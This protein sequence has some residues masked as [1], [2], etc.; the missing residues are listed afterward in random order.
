ME[1]WKEYRLSELCDILSGGTPKTTEPKYWGGGIPW[2]SVKDFGNVDKY[3][4]TTEK[5]ITN[6][7]FEH[8]P[9]KMLQ[10]DDIIISARGTVGAIAMISSSMS[11]N[12]SCFGLRG[13][14]LVDK[15]F[16]YYLMHTKVRELRSNSHGSVF[17][18]ITRNTFDNIICNIP[19]KVI[20]HKIATI[21]SFLDDKIELNRKINSNLEEQAKALF[22]SWFIDF[23]PFKDGKFVDSELGKIPEGWKVGRYDDIVSATVVGDWGKDKPIGNYVHEVTCIRGCD[24]QDIKNGLTGN[25]PSRF[26]LE[27]NFKNKCFANNDILVEISGGTQTV[28]TGR[29]CPISQELISRYN[30]NVVCTNFCRVLRPIE[31]YSAFI[32]YSWLYK[33]NHKVMFGY[34]NGTSGIKNFRLNDFLSMEPLIIPPKDKVAEFQKVIDTINA[35]MQ[36][37]GLESSKL[38]ETRDSLLPRLMSGEIDV[39]S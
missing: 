38:V 39:R 15:H 10:K 33:Y 19:S 17:D 24:F 2:L 32:Y 22:K 20:Q 25:A 16:L 37:T 1:Q 21:L 31:E 8:C 12:Q 7:G 28:S 29:V 23:E 34:E 11:F 6:V 5:T 30:G 4:Y 27:K 26:I 14:D 9:S 35:Q 18:T 3:V 13:N 36:T